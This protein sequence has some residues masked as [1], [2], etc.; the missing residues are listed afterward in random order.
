MLRYQLALVVVAGCAHA[1]NPGTGTDANGGDDDDDANPAT[2][3]SGQVATDVGSDGSVTCSAITDATKAAITA[4]CSAYLGFRDGCDG[5]T[6]APAKWGNAGASCA[7][8]IGGNDTCQTA[9]LGSASVALFGLNTDG[10]VNDDDKL[11][12]GLHC[13]APMPMPSTAPCPAGSFITGKIGS[14]YECTPL[15][16]AAIDYVRTSCS[17]YLG[18]QDGCGGCET[19][20]A[21][22]GLAGDGGCT[23]GVGVDDTCIAAT[24]G[25]ESVNL[26]GLNPDGDVDD[27]DKIHV[28]LH[29]T[30]PA[31]MT[32][33]ATSACPPGELVTG[34]AT[35]GSF[36][37]TSVAPQVHDYFAQHCSLYFGWRDSCDGCSLP[38][39]KWGNV[40]D[41][42]CTLG[43]GAND[44]CTTFSLGGTSVAMFGLNPGGDVD[45]NDKLYMSLHCD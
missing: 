43:V 28:G 23:N 10:N 3:Q 44:T 30:T 32:M 33:T 1:A 8:G 37:C 2:C 36:Q 34:T 45:D 15:A 41:G 12:T 20:P 18:W 26:F 19:P 38:P 11:Y 29:C 24:L 42:T 14:S 39:T 27:N 4:G 35:D 16:V 6:T 13:I 9:E 7:L 21:K 5:C 17:I 40:L 25:T 31:P 22:W